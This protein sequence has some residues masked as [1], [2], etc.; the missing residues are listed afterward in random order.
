[1]PYPL[2]DDDEDVYGTG[3]GMPMGGLSILSGNPYTTPEALKY[4]REILDA[5]NKPDEEQDLYMAKVK[6]N[7]DRARNAI[8]SARDRISAQKYGNTEAWLAAASGFG[9][10]TRTGSFG[11][12]AGNVAR[13]LIEPIQKKRAFN[14]AKDKSL[15]DLD[16]AETNVDD[17]T[18]KSN[19]EL[20]KLRLQAKARMETE[21][22]KQVGKQLPAGGSKAQTVAQNAA[23]RAY[24]KE[25]VK[26]ATE[27]GGS[28]AIKSIDDLDEAT[29][30]LKQASAN[31][32]S[33]L[34]GPIVGSVATI[35]FVG[36]WLQDVANP[37]SANIQE[38][39]EYTVQQSLRPILG[40]QFTEKEGERLI[41]RVFN[42]RLDEKVNARRLEALTKMLKR[43]YSTK[44]AAK[45][46]WEKYGTLGPTPEN[47]EGFQGQV[48]WSRRDIEDGWKSELDKMDGKKPKVKGSSEE[49]PQFDILPDD[50]VLE[51]EDMVPARARGGKIRRFAE[52]GGV[53]KRS[54]YK[55]PDGRVIRAPAGVTY[56]QVFDRYNEMNG[57]KFEKPEPLE[58]VDV[59]ADRK[60]LEDAK[61]Q[62]FEMGDVAE[63]GG[64]MAAGALGARGAVGAGHAISDL[65]PGRRVR[66]GESR[67]LSALDKQG[68]SPA[69]WTRLTSQANK[70]GVP[71]MGIDTGGLQMRTLGEAAMN[72]ENLETREMYNTLRDRQKG[73]RSRV[74]EQVNKSLKPDEYF[75]KEKELIGNI[76]NNSA[77]DY[78]ELM[79]KFPSLKSPALVQL[80]DTPSGKEAVK[81]A[82]K[83]IR[84]VPGATISKADVTGMVK[85][86]DIR[87]LDQVKQEFDDLVMEAEGS[88]PNY[89][90]TSEGRRI[91][92]LRKALRDEMD[93]ATT[94]PKT[95]E[96]LYQKARSQYAGDIEVLDQ[97]RFGREEFMRKAPKELEGHL[98]NLNFTEKDALRTGVAQKI[99]ETLR[100]P[101][102]KDFNAAQKLIGSP[103]TEEKLRLLFDKP[104]EFKV[105]KRALEMEAEMYQDSR[106]TLSAAQ[107]AL[108]KDDGTKLGAV[109]RTAKK[110]PTLGIMSPIQ[111][112][113][114]YF[115]KKPEM[116]SKESAEILKMLRTSDS[117][118]L[119]ELEQNLTGKAGRELSRK[120]R[121][122]KAGIAG[123][124]V[125][126]ALPFLGNENNDDETIEPTENYARGGIAEQV[127][128]HSMFGMHP[129]HLGN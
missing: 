128:N 29:N 104:A 41:S 113:I 3:A 36:K 109:R 101:T 30:A 20:M 74:E 60:P 112:A 34:T 10:P 4:S 72:P 42:P 129:R 6:A 47:P 99:S 127:L 51:W 11:E 8:R 62:M 90:A 82:M 98:S 121:K 43:A 63:L 25:Y 40:A 97:L 79:T 73:S 37:E 15:L 86:F 116:G 38:L 35:P 46:Y 111:W 5:R 50:P 120:R 107:R 118:G 55:M 83:S 17:D 75:A 66:P 124:L 84:D 39:V 9:S 19:L 12:T 105:F 76:R 81:R 70:Y 1:M 24:A 28:D 102:S 78:T 22:L 56:D 119:A 69:E 31:G 125:A 7:A 87:F 115:R 85:N 21:A 117:K 52:G 95:K 122:G 67:V 57:N 100:N 14:Q 64:S 2:D 94:D 18:L 106:P 68:L 26:F 89:K 71:A 92:A 123:A 16:L 103:E 114:R 49:A 96:S 110:A 126:G 48:Q 93:V 53:G 23:D 88:G 91:R 33:N 108:K 44:V 32:K 77:P 61:R 45:D 80:L 13:S 54:E 65:M 27:S 59:N 58:E